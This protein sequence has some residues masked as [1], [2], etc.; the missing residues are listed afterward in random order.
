[1]GHLVV[2]LGDVFLNT[3]FLLVSAF[4]KI[5]KTYS[6]IRLT[7]QKNFEW[8]TKSSCVKF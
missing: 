5:N 8:L 2:G 3:F 7:H 6:E 4:H 1:M